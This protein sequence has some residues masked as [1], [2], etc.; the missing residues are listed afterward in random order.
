M[1][2][3]PEIDV[4]G[5]DCG[6][7]LPDDPEDLSFA[8]MLKRLEQIVEELESG[9]L[10]LEQSLAKFEEGVSLARKLESVLARA[11]SRVQEILKADE[12]GDMDTEETDD[13]GGPCQEARNTARL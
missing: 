3:K 10:S 13:F 1:S 2:S 5:M 6:K 11:E 7:P 12:A 9:E 8:D 4:P